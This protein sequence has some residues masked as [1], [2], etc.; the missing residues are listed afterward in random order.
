LIYSKESNQLKLPKKFPNKLNYEEMKQMLNMSE[1]KV[2]QGTIH[3]M[4]SRDTSIQNSAF[5]TS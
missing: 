1:N 3:G 4:Q 5:L 2:I